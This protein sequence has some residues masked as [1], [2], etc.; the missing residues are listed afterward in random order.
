LN[1]SR[2]LKNFDWKYSMM[3]FG[4][5]DCEMS[6]CSVSQKKLVYVK[7]FETVFFVEISS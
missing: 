5:C 7:P 6:N 3:T 2:E 4:V 1:W